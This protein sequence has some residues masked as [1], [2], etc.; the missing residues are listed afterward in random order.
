MQAGKIV[1][2]IDCGTKMQV[3]CTDERGL[4]SVY[5]ENSLFNSFY[6]TIRK[7][8][9]NPEGLQIVFD[10]NIVQIPSLR[11]QCYCSLD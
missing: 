9:L 2:I 5:F 7:A 8:G 3:L 4:L 6:Q 11:K 10:R 1:K